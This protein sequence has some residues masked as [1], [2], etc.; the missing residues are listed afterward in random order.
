M[1]GHV[2]AGNPDPAAADETFLDQPRR[3]ELGGV[4]G[5]G[6]T[7]SLRGKNDRGVYPDDFTARIDQ[8]AAGI[9]G[10]QCRI[11]LD[12]IVNQPTGLGAHGAA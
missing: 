7:N 4:A 3:H 12:D 2:L 5:D 11:G 9:P 1:N 8:R 6:K 10:I